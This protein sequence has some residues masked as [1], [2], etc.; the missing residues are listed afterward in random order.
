MR[1][2]QSPV[3]WTVVVA[4]LVILVIFCIK[5]TSLVNVN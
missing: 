2:L 1:V 5:V 3:M 4:V